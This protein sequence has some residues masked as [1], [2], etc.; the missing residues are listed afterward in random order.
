MSLKWK[1]WQEMNPAEK[2]A[3]RKRRVETMNALDRKITQGIEGLVTSERWT[4]YLRFHSRFHEYSFRNSLLIWL[5]KPE[6][7]LVAS[8]KTWK[9]VGRTPRKGTGIQILFP[10]RLRTKGAEEEGEP[11]SGGE[12][13]ADL[14]RGR[15]VFRVGHVFDVSD[16]EGA[17]LPAPVVTLL[18]GDDEGLNAALDAFI[19]GVLHLPVTETDDRGLLPSGNGVLYFDMGSGR[20]A[21]IFIRQGNPPLQKAKTRLHEAAHALLHSREQYAGQQSRSVEELE[22]ESVAY[23]VLSHFGIDSGEYSFGYLSLWGSGAGAIE[24]FRQSGKRITDAARRI[25]DWIEENY[26]PEPVAI[27]VDL[28]EPAGREVMRIA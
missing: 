13:G 26:Q 12:T 16:T 8:F 23:S 3:A 28:R 25:I 24:A 10:L 5:Q 17:P 1:A 20:P 9:E 19:Q 18:T 14:E 15:I 7:T 2:E 21:K 6:A 4:A 22:A 27:P 11:E